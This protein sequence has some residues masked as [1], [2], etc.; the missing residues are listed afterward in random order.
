MTE[1]IEPMSAQVDQQQ[2]AK[3]LVDTRAEGVDLVGPD[4]ALG[5]NNRLRSETAFAHMCGADPI[6]ASSGKTQRHRLSPAAT[7]TPT[8]PCT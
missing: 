6:P 1:T 2:L 5:N 3:E 7:A 8:A 4:G